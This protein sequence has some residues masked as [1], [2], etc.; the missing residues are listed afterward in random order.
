[1]VN[2]LLQS[3]VEALCIKYGATKPDARIL[4]A[5]SMVEAPHSEGGKSYSDFD[6]V[7]DQELA[8]E[9]WGFS[10]GGF[11]VRSLRSHLN[12]GLHRDAS[13]LPDPVFNVK[14]ALQIL[15]E[16][17]FS[18]WSTYNTGQ[19]K[20]LLQDEFPPPPGTYVVVPGDS[21]SKIASLLKVGTW[22]DI[23][24]VNALKSPYTIFIGQALLL[25]YFLYTVKSGDTL[26]G[27]VVKYGDGVTV[28][29]VKEFNGITDAN[30]IYP[31]QVIRIPRSTL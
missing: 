26:S 18:A 9:K 31:D 2:K 25:P 10:Y 27:I 3:E 1:M 29:R 12:T 17:G 19:Y 22:Q 5:I 6:R 7:G 15:K 13:R 30:K 14:S 28:D 11:Q 23:A 20:A 24:R 4:A 8:N 16:Q 21:L